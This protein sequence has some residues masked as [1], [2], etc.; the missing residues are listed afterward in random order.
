MDEAVLEGS[1]IGAVGGLADMPIPL[2]W[3][4]LDEMEEF[5]SHEAGISANRVKLAIVRLESLGIA[6]SVQ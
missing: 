5:E 3:P 6:T 4:S 2:N 1:A